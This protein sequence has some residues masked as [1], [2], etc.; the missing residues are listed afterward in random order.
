VLE[1]ILGALSVCIRL[2]TTCLRCAIPYRPACASSSFQ[3]SAS[4]SMLIRLVSRPGRLTFLNR[5]RPNRKCLRRHQIG[6]QTVKLLRGLC[7]SHKLQF[8]F[9]LLC[10]PRSVG[11]FRS[12]AYRLPS[13][14]RGAIPLFCRSWRS[15]ARPAKLV[16]FRF[17]PDLPKF[18]G[19]LRSRSRV[20]LFLR[21]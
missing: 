10:G 15:V 4:T 2:P 18:F 3:K 13:R 6:G 11:F 19:L 16:R 12:E 1:S 7:F 20:F 8:P 5:F 21:N 9:L 17:R 14:F